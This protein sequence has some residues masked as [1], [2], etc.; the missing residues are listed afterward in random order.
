MRED[1]GQ[2]VVLT[3]STCIPACCPFDNTI[4]TDLDD[5]AVSRSRE[6]RRKHSK[7]KFFAIKSLHAY[8]LADYYIGPSRSI[9]NIKYYM[10]YE[11]R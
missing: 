4:D 2:L 9:R 7:K 5:V 1:T 3:R 10:E 6:R 8:N 11:E